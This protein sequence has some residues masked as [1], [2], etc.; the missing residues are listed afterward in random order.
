MAQDDW[1]TVTR[2]REVQSKDGGTD[3][4]QVMWGTISTGLVLS[5]ILIL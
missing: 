4:G 2:N 5:L 3:V 1:G